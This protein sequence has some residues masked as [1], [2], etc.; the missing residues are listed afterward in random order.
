MHRIIASLAVAA[1][2]SV[3]FGSAPSYSQEGT[4]RSFDTIVVSAGRHAEATR[5]VT[6]NITVIDS[7]AIERTVGTTLQALMVEQGFQAYTFGGS[8][9]GNAASSLIYIRGYGQSSMAYSEINAMSLIL[10]NGHR[11][12]NSY[13]NMV[14]LANIERVEVIR[15]PA[16]VQYGA[17]ALGGIVNVITKRGEG[18]LTGSVEAGFGSWS[19]RT[20]ML[21]LSGVT[22]PLDF[23]FGMSSSGYDDYH[24]GHGHVY[25]HTKVDNTTGYDIDLGINF[26]DTQRI[27]LHLNYGGVNGEVTGQSE[28]IQLT[29]PNSYSRVHNYAYNGTISYEGS[30][31]DGHLSWL[32]NYTY[33][34]SSMRMQSFTDPND[35][36][37]AWGALYP[38]PSYWND[39]RSDMD[40]FQVQM[41]YDHPYFSLTPGFESVKYEGNSLTS[42]SNGVKSKTRFKNYAAFLLAKLRLL[43]GDLIFSAGGRYDKVEETNYQTTYNKSKFTPSFGVA[44]SPVSF[45]KLRANYSEGFS[46]PNA[47]QLFGDGSSYLP[48]PDLVPQENKTIEFGLDV[49]YDFFE[50]SATYFISDF[51]NKF[52]GVPT[53][54]PRPYSGMYNIFR[55]LDGAALAGLEL[56]L[57]YDIA[58]A[59]GQNFSLKP[60]LNLTWMTKRENKV[61]TA[62]V[63]YVIPD[64]SA[65]PY[66]PDLLMSY[67]LTFD[68]PDIGL[69][70]NIN[71]S[72]FGK[73]YVNDWYDLDYIAA[74][75]VGS[76]TAPWIEHGGFTVV[77]LSVTKRVLD[78]GGHGH[79]DFKGQVGNLFDAAEGYA[80]GITIPGR[81]FYAG[82]V[83]NF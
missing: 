13:I 11:T 57:S 8:D 74:A 60:Y 81:N 64:P 28:A 19:K 2:F 26:L 23:S 20:G 34:R 72:Y 24:T 35:V 66:T 75:L 80:A 31:N 70:A 78:F 46:V 50:G 6:S 14:P 42:Y 68:Y 59:M 45:L 4:E 25:P 67:G 47:D 9:Y 79:L 52:I 15:G 33:A 40:Q 56:S 54:I 29:A 27:G 12:N 61:G 16:A 10:L 43:D 21:G 55:N 76:A 63:S 17:S 3:T 7:E 58:R 65:L 82:L 48:S 38:I 22:G 32:T 5:E 36:W 71:A 1:V 44:Y 53:N 73:S 83:Y 49:S 77:N 37:G 69:N 51:K 39:N 41:T 30:A 18:P 62:A